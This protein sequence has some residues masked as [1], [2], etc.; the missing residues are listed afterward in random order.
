MSVPVP[1]P[2]PMFN[3]LFNLLTE[4]SLFLLP[5]D[6]AVV[7][8]SLVVTGINSGKANPVGQL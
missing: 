4:F 5:V 1:M 7:V 3:C 8:G 6:A 2:V